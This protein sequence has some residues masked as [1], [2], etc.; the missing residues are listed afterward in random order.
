MEC[1]GT[2]FSIGIAEAPDKR[3]AQ[4][5]SDNPQESDFSRDCVGLSNLGEERAGSHLE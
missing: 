2:R 5:N 3:L 4:Y 1:L